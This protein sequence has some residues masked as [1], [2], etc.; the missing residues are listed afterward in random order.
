M[1]LGPNNDRSQDLIISRAIVE[2]FNNPVLMEE[3][4][5]RG[6][7]ALNKLRLPSH[8]Q[9]GEDEVLLLMGNPSPTKIFTKELLR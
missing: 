5:F 3:L 9:K 7:M 4:R 2:T 1:L 8:N 6:G